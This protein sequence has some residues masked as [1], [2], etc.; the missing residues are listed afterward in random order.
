MQTFVSETLP[1]AAAGSVFTATGWLSGTAPN[2]L[3]PGKPIPVDP[4]LPAGT[5]I[6]G[7]CVLAMHVAGNDPHPEPFPSLRVEFT[8]N[9]RLFSLTCERVDP[10]DSVQFFMWQVTYGHAP[11]GYVPTSWISGATPGANVPQKVP[12]GLPESEAFAGLNLLPIHFYDNDPNP[13][14]WESLR[15]S[16]TQDGDIWMEDSG[17]G[18]GPRD[19]IQTFYWQAL[20]VPAEVAPQ[21]VGWISG[22]TRD[23]AL[24]KTITPGIPTG[25][26]IVSL[27]L[28]PIHVYKNDPKPEPWPGLRAT[29]NGK[30]GFDIT[31]VANDWRDRIDWFMWQVTYANA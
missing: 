5:V 23:A 29:P 2:T 1:R 17:K 9:A 4:Q 15:L 30:G 13:E 28:L 20:A 24:P 8:T 18:S 6:L 16:L 27:T 22:F 31:A 19:S 7:V 25:K 14:P 26:S 21:S 11:T 3:A 10:R 12:V